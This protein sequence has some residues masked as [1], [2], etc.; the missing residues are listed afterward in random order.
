[1]LQK[2]SAYNL[3]YGQPLAFSVIEEACRSRGDTVIGIL[4]EHGVATAPARQQQFVL[5]PE[6]R[7]V[8]V[9]HEYQQALSWG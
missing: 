5:G 1:M 8:I 3:P 7:L 2:A 9:T 6:H 4:Q